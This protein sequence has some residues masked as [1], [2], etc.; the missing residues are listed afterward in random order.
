M[1]W[2]DNLRAILPDGLETAIEVL[3]AGG[4][5]IIVA[6]VVHR[7]ACRVLRRL[8]AA[9]AGQADDIVVESIIRPLRWVLIAIALVLVARELPALGA[10]WERI[11]GF[12]VPAL[13]GWMALA[14]FRAFIRTM[15]LGADTSVP[16]NLHARS[17]QTRLSILSRIGTG[18][19][20]FLTVSMMLLSIPG[21]RDIGVTLMASAGLAALAVGA[22]AQPALKSLI[23]GIQMALT[24]PIR[25][26]D[27]VVLDGELGRIEDIRTTFVV[28]RLWD[29][30]RMIVPTTRFLEDT[31]QNWTRDGSQI[32]GTAIL[33]L[34]PLA[35]IARLRTEF[36]RLMKANPLWDGRTQ[37]LQVTETN[38]DTIQV[39]MVMSAASSGASFDL[40]C[41]IREGMLAWIRE[42]MPEAIKGHQKLPAPAKP[43]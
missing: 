33:H 7:I 20:I 18:L 16:D 13:V 14:V 17:R 27:V 5:A 25:I 1:D 11:A 31:F 39:R 24:Q 3:L 2:L 43:A 8:A 4:L 15:M 21:V 42:N 35:D 37:N 26:D 40:A 23:A 41:A 36:E 19:I 6:L 22:A 12:V 34:D 38:V 29:E 10:V 30:R 32:T 9:S 28:V